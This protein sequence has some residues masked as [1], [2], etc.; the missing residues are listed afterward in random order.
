[1]LDRFFGLSERRTTVGAELMGGLTTFMVMAYI[2]FVN[3]AILSF[4]GIK[5]LEGQGPPFAPTLA[6]TCLVAGLATIAMDPMMY[7]ATL[8]FLVYV[9]LPWLR[10]LFGF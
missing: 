5:G 7:G 10:P 4:A 2:I 3:P 8:A 6:A 1:M 9:A